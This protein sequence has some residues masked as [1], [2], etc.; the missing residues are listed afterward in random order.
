ML[1]RLTQAGSHAIPYTT[2]FN[3]FSQSVLRNNTGAVAQLSAS[4]ILD[5]HVSDSNPESVTR[6]GRHVISS[7]KILIHRLSLELDKSSIIFGWGYR[8]ESISSVAGWHVKVCVLPH[9]RG[10]SRICE[11]IAE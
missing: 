8:R 7:T 6:A 10:I 4:R 9:K 2:T 5:P 3:P 1:Q 11:A